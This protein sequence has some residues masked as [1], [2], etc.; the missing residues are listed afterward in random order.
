MEGGGRGGSC[1]GWQGGVSNPQPGEGGI[2]AGGLV[3][4]IGA[5]GRNEKEGESL[6]GVGSPESEECNVC[7][8][9]SSC[10]TG[11]RLQ[12]RPGEEGTSP[13][14]FPRAPTAMGGLADAFVCFLFISESAPA[15]PPT[16]MSRRR[17]R[18]SPQYP[19]GTGSVSGDMWHRVSNG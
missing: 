4:G 8:E 19:Q 11:G 9:G 13:A 17:R 2:Q 12:P 3:G 16:F 14:W 1:P 15:P 5:R 18:W 10:L 6:H 7:G